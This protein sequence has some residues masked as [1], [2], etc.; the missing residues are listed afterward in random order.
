[1]ELWGP[2]KMASEMGN[3]GEI[4]PISR[5]ISPYSS[6]VFWAQPVVGYVV[7]FVLVEEILTTWR[8]NPLS[9]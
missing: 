2:F 8:I 9:K 7:L 4:T 3:W 1:M 6:L 5:V